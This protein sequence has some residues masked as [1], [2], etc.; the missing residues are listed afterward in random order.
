MEIAIDPA[1]LQYLEFIKESVS[2]MI[3]V[4]LALVTGVAWRF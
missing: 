4:L 3:G 1:V 2:M